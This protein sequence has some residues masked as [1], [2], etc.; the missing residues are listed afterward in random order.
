MANS[1]TLVEKSNELMWNP[2]KERIQSSQ[3]L[4][5]KNYIEE[6]EKTKFANY[7][8][9]HHW[10]VSHKEIFWRH[11]F[12]F[13]KL[14]YDGALEPTLLHD[15]FTTYSWF[16]HV[17]LSFIENLLQ[18]GKDEAIAIK[19]VHES[20]LAQK[21]TYKQLKQKI[22][23]LAQ[24]LKD[25]LGPEDVCAAYMP[26]IPETIISMGA[27]NSLGGIFTSTSSDF[28]I[29]GVVDRFQQS[30]PTV[31]VAAVGYTYNGKYFDQ[32]FKL[33]EIIKKLPSLKRVYL[34][35]FF[36]KGDFAKIKS[37]LTHADVRNLN[38]VLNDS[39]QFKNDQKFIK[40]S[41][42]APLYIM[43]SS[44]TTGKP[45]CIVHGQGGT[46][47][48]HIKEIGLHGDF[49]ADKNMFF[50]TTCGWMMWNWLTSALFFGGT[51][52]LYDGAPAYPSFNSF[53]QKLAN[54]NVSILGTSPKFLKALADSG[55]NKNVQFNNLETLLSTGSPLL[56]EQYDFVY[57]KFK[58]DVLLGSI[59]GGTD[60]IGCF[61]L[62][63]PMLPV[64]RGEIQC[65]GLGMDV[66]SFDEGG[67]PVLDKEGE[68]VCRQT[69]P[70]RPI[71]FLNDPNNEKITQAYF[72]K[73]PGIWHHGDFVT[74]SSG[75]GVKVFGRSDATLNPGGVR[76]GTAEIYCQTENFEFLLDSLAVGRPKDGDVEVLLFVKMKEGESLNEERVLK[77]K[78]CIKRGTTPR[79][80]PSFIYVVTDIP[81][82]RSGK[83][84][85]L[86]VSRILAGKNPD[87]LEAVANPE[88]LGEFEKFRI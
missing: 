48:Q 69:F 54:E 87:N 17:K 80:V 62:A 70:S 83:K 88:C 36:N 29:E 22:G 86:A 53:L 65:L 32:T 85:E 4:K 46:L 71:G 39:A 56:P 40:R 10:S 68:L 23:I 20:D 58:E 59:S 55:Y 75:G 41:F 64:R 49:N 60:I 81:Y 51:I 14:K 79:H 50:F 24:D 37:S 3:I 15:N 38:L 45:K 47:L 63:S 84:M 8:Q 26:N 16:P 57:S 31:L 33:Q 66:A 74:L 43:Y 73:Y 44:G 7:N 12:E 76:I 9:L 13:F 19:F 18:H 82:T 78:D 34:I 25:V 61:M 67:R 35:D 11:L 6:K 5:F 21:I 52:T 27:T 28:G 72:A 2:S 30:N 42:G 1:G 77:I